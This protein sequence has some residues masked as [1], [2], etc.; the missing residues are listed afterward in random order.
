MVGLG[1]LAAQV[2]RKNGIRRT[3]TDG[4]EAEISAYLVQS[5]LTR[6][7]FDTLASGVLPSDAPLQEFLATKEGT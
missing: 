4:V 7:Q 3:Y 1:M 2:A 6:T 5:G